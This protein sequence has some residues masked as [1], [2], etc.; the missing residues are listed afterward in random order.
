VLTSTFIHTPGVGLATERSLWEQGATNWASYL[1]SAQRLKIDSRRRDAL[2]ETVE[3]S[4]ASLDAGSIDYFARKL[5]RKEQWRALSA[6]GERIAF[7]D[8]ET[9][10]GYGSDCVTLIG[11]SDGFDFYHYVKGDNL[12]KFERDCRDYDVFVTF[13]GGPFDIPFII[14][15]FPKLQSFFASRLHVDLC[16]LLRRL[17]HTGGLKRIEEELKIHRIPETEGLNGYDAVRLWRIYERGGRGADDALRLLIA[18]NREDVVNMKTLL[19]YTVPKLEE[20]I[21]WASMASA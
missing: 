15:R 2:M 12:A 6:F 5:P 14:R 1:E 7:V 13:N 4:M 8:I 19:D 11:L 21:G 17:G 18:Y 3:E 20:E 10:N 9:D 16:P